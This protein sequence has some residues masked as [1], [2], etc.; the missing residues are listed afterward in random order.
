[1][2]CIGWIPNFSADIFNT[3]S[4]ILNKLTNYKNYKNI[5]EQDKITDISVY[6]NDY[7]INDQIGIDIIFENP[8]F[9]QFILDTVHF[10]DIV[11]LSYD[12]KEKRILFVY[13]FDEENMNHPS[14][15]LIFQDTINQTANSVPKNYNFKYLVDVD[16]RKFDKEG[17]IIFSIPETKDKYLKL[18]NIILEEKDVLKAI[19]PQNFIINC[20]YNF[21]NL[22]YIDILDI[23]KDGN[24][25]YE[26]KPCL[27]D[28]IPLTDNNE[29]T[30][31]IGKAIIKITDEYL[32][33]MN[34]QM[35]IISNILNDNFYKNNEEAIKESFHFYRKRIQA[36]SLY[37]MT[38]IKYYSDYLPES[39]FFYYNTIFSNSI[40]GI[41]ILYKDNNDKF[42]VN[43]LNRLQ[44]IGEGVKLGLEQMQSMGS[45]VQTILKRTHMLA[46]F[47]FFAGALGI[48]AVLPIPNL[49]EFSKWWILFVIYSFMALLYFIC[50]NYQKAHPTSSLA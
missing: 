41:N 37:A 2:I 23:V 32:K 8:L 38:F 5:E 48:F 28:Q 44:D 31:N 16:I 21:I 1:M 12:Q 29:Y 24:F 33:F 49:S 3:N 34:R 22:Y 14:K 30:Y 13:L 50:I 39:K 9:S 36:T 42:Y 7:N 4:F 17:M 20:F 15:I 10:I 25:F 18:N 45:D 47:A 27:F 6:K 19:L 11:N 26:I 35:N 46:I 40:S 43:S